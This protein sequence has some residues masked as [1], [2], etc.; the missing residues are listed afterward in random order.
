M[1]TIQQDMLALKEGILFHQVNCEGVMGSGIAAALA[2]KFPGLEEEYQQFCERHSGGKTPNL[3][4]KVFVFRVSPS[5]YVVNVFGQSFAVRGRSRPTNYEAVATSFESFL[6]ERDQL[7]QVS[8]PMY[9][10]Y[11]MGCGL[12]GGEW[13]IYAAMIEH[14][15]PCGIIC[16]HNA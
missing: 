9:F 16:Q 11:K 2:K 14:Y 1:K 12:G 6:A 7:I 15:F 13:S 4:G 10:P 3:L 5:L 8:W